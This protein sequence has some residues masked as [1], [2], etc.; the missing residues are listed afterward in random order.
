MHDCAVASVFCQ[1]CH[2]HVR[3]QCCCW[4]IAPCAC[5]QQGLSDPFVSRLSVDPKISSLSSEG[6]VEDLVRDRSIRIQKIIVS[7]STQNR[8][9]L[10][11]LR[12][13]AC[14]SCF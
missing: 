7:T 8:D 13:A 10:E 2:C 3:D 9:L 12:K 1:S 4:L 6:L 14:K 11:R 5:A